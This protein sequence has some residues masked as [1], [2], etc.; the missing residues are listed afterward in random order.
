MVPK[1][2]NYDEFGEAS[3]TMGGI[4][5]GPGRKRGD[6]SFSSED[7]FRRILK[8]ETAVAKSND[9]LRDDYAYNEYTTFG[10]GKLCSFQNLYTPY[11]FVSTG[12]ILNLTFRLINQSI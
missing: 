11:Q 12:Q 9:V 5:K 2:K 4:S 8:D 6:G 7:L 1:R 3:E 10:T